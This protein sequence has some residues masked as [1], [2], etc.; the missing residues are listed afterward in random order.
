MTREIEP[1]YELRFAALLD[2]WHAKHGSA[3][4]FRVYAE[5]RDYVFSQPVKDAIG[6]TQS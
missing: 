1:L 3:D 5:L 2:E 6:G 4:Q